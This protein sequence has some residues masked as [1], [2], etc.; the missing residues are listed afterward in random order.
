M[1]YIIVGCGRLGGTLAPALVN[2]GNAIAII[3]RDPQALRRLPPDFRGR[4]I[5]GVAFDQAVLE[6]AGIAQADGL[7]TVTNSDNTNFVL[8]AVARWR[9]RVP[10]V[11]ARIYDPVRADIYR[12]L[13]I[14]TFS[15][16]AWGA[17]RVRDLLTYARLRAS[18]EIGNGEVKVVEIEIGPL[19]DG[20]PAGELNVAEESQVVAVVRAGRGFIPTPATPLRVHDQV[21][22]AVLASGA[23]RLERMVET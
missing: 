23:G 6:R 13:G 10:R 19:L 18:L 15:P 1:R 8:A 3:D 20:H 14:P 2:E 21:Q 5:E 12:H 7:A 22:V 9:Y 16:T 11:V 17:G 4:P